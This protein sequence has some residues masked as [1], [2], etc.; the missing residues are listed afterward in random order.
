[1]NKYP[2]TEEGA[3]QC[4]LDM[5]NELIV[6]HFGPDSGATWKIDPSFDGV[7][8]GTAKIG[9]RAIVYMA[10]YPEGITDRIR[11]HNDF[12]TDLESFPD[13]DLYGSVNR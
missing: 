3:R 8:Q 1:M 10:G 4:L 9:A 12:E 13:E 6:T 2:N 5:G 7:W 11:S